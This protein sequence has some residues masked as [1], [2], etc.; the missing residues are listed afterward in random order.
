VAPDQ[1]EILTEKNIQGTPAVLTAK[2]NDTLETPLLTG[3]SL[4]LSRL[5]R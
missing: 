3:W 4:A 2:G 1:F 5:F